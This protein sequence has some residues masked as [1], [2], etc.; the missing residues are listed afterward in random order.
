MVKQFARETFI[1]LKCAG[2]VCLLLPAD[3]IESM[4]IIAMLSA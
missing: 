2:H 3:A 1:S 4:A